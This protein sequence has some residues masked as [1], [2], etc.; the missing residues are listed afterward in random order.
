M[1]IMKYIFLVI[2]IGFFVLSGCS[3]TQ[4]FS[5]AVRAG[6]TV[7]HTVGMQTGV[8]RDNLTITFTPL[9]GGASTIYLPGDSAVR[10]VVNLY[11]DPVSRIIVGGETGQEL[12]T[13][14]STY[15]AA[16]ENTLA[17]QSKDWWSTMVVFDVPSSLPIGAYNAEMVS[18][19]NVMNT[20]TFEVVDAGGSANTFD[21]HEGGPLLPEML[22]SMERAD[23]Y[24]IDFTGTTVPYA[25]QVEFLHNPDEALGGTG[26][27]YVIN[28][29]GDI[30]N[31]AWTDDGTSMRVIVTPARTG[32]SKMEHFKFYVA[33][34]ITGLI[35]QLVEA[36][37]IN[38]NPV[39]GV[40]VVATPGN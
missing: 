21:T 9:A 36:Y 23:N 7:S 10:A 19:G 24:S 20:A 40:S 28:S 12:G 6:D 30:K 25:L 16:L 32:L 11:P 17:N 8:S 35:P 34:G 37:D 38:G 3:G 14:A 5:T 33:G 15:N 39:T 13:F 1:K 18:N 27:P 29:R 31:V 26:R 4:T 2:Y 22:Y